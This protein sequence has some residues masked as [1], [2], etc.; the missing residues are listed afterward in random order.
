MELKLNLLEEVTTDTFQSIL[1]KC[2]LNTVK[3]IL[4]KMPAY[5][6]TATLWSYSRVALKISVKENPPSGWNVAN[7][8]SC[9]LCVK[10]ETVS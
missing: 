9:L 7:I 2:N 1:L 3:C 4:V 6:M 5:R 8:S 10:G